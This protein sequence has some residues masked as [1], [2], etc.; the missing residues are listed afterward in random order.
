MILTSSK[1]NVFLYW[2]F[3]NSYVIRKAG[4]K[5]NEDSSLF[6]TTSYHF[7]PLGD[8]TEYSRAKQLDAVLINLHINTFL[9]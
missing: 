7:P 6:D 8:V 5:I 1:I 3:Y 2:L 9:K 4:K